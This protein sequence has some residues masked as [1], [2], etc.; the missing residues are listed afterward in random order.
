MP[1]IDG[2]PDGVTTTQVTHQDGGAALAPGG[3]GAGG[4]D[5]APTE[6]LPPKET[7]QVQQGKVAMIPHAQFARVK[8]D[9]FNK[10]KAAALDEIAKA[11]GFES[12]ADLVAALGRLK[13]MGAQPPA[14]ETDPRTPATKEQPKGDEAPSQTDVAAMRA[15][16]REL[17][18]V[19]K[20]NEKL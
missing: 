6:V 9:E 5:A 14:T 12:N 10:G 20:M 3:G 2:T 4:A 8:Q 7:A 15:E 11:S 13:S 18:R 17:Q 16:K 1:T 19:E